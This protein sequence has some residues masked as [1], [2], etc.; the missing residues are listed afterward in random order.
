MDVTGRIARRIL[1][2]GVTALVVPVAVFP[3]QFGL[4]L[5]HFAA[6][7]LFYEVVYYGVISYLFKREGSLV[8]L[9][10]S[11]ILCL[12]FRLALG[13]LFGMVISVLYGMQFSVSLAL[14]VSSYLPTVA[15]HIAVTPFILKPIIDQIV[16]STRRSRVVISSV[17]PEPLDQADESEPAP[18]TVENFT[19]PS[20]FNQTAREPQTPFYEPPMERHAPAAPQNPGEIN[21]FERAVRYI[22]EHG[23][24]Y[25]AAVVDHEGLLMA[26]FRRGDFVPDDWAPLALLFHE[27]NRRVLAR[28]GLSDPDRVD[29]RLTDKRVVTAK[30]NNYSLMVV[31][32]RQSDDVL[33]IRISQGLEIISKYATERYASMQDGNAER[34][35]V[36]GTE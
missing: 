13:V 7:Y 12:G 22:G 28:N 26:S 5:A 32:D 18:Q 35:H 30:Q 33:N 16:R 25:L 27:S 6:V 29:L 17:T 21:G 19:P 8:Q 14:G 24:V 20:A 23:A 31:A 36:S 1:L 9:G 4:Q 10:Q 34:I 3:E 15:F 11:A 2:F